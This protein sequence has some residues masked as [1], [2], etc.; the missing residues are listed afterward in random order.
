MAIRNTSPAQHFAIERKLDKESARIVAELKLAQSLDKVE[1][2]TVPVMSEAELFAALDRIEQDNEIKGLMER[3]EIVG[4][5]G[6]AA[7]D[8]Q[9]STGRW[10]MGMN[11]R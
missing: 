8:C 6:V 9:Y 10:G 1:A 5:V 7:L 4:N 11:G 2:S 3:T